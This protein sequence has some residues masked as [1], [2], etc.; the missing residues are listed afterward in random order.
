M[1]NNEEEYKLKLSIYSYEK[2]DVII[3]IFFGILDLVFIILFSIYLKP[4]NK[5]V[6]HLKQK[7]LQLFLIDFISR[8]L[9]TKKYTS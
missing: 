9:Y 8:L 1:A 2:S 3:S 4:Q 6:N 7:L 5:K